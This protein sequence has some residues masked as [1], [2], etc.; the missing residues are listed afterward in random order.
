MAFRSL[1][2][3]SLALRFWSTHDAVDTLAITAFIELQP[4][5]ADP[6]QNSYFLCLMWANL[7]VGFF[8]RIL[9]FKQIWMTGGLFGGRPIN[10]LT[11][12]LRFNIYTKFNFLIF[13][14]QWSSLYNIGPTLSHSSYQ[15]EGVSQNFLNKVSQNPVFSFG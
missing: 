12:I 15:G 4:L 3:Q 11:G 5:S 13:S 6:V 10:L 9:V 1:P 7:F 14:N 2:N 8:Y